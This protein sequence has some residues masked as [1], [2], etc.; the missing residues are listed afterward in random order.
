MSED[1]ALDHPVNTLVSYY[2]FEKRDLAGLAA[3]GLRL[4]GDSGA[5]SADSQGAPVDRDLFHDWARKWRGDLFWTAALDVIGDAEGTWQNWRSSPPDLRLVP[6]LHYGCD[7][8]EMDRYVSEGV[9]LLGLGGMVRYRSEPKRLLRWCLQVMRYARDTH[10]QV[11]FHGWGVT[12][13]ALLMNLPWW[14]VDSSGFASAYRYGRLQLW[15]PDTKSRQLVAMDGRQTAAV[16]R[17]LKDHYGV[18]WRRIAESNRDTRRDLVRVSIRS[19]QLMEQYLQRRHRV[20]PPPSLT[21][22]GAGPLV[23]LSLGNPTTQ[24]YHALQPDELGPKVH[25]V[26]AAEQHLRMAG[27]QIYTAALNQPNHFNAL[28]ER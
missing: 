26:D 8:R 25:F 16:A 14:S 21:A 20:T 15:N 2:Y 10:P 27:P 6:T 7:P 28:R 5:F 3:L 9:D 1:V 12:H 11:R 19:M 13:P 23:H 22:D 18:D 24:A 4:I 17:L